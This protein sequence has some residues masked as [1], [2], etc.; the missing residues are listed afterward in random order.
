VD[1]IYEDVASPEQADI[2]LKNCRAFLKKGGYAMIAIKS[3]SID[4]TRP[5]E[6]TYAQVEGELTRELELIERINLEPFEMGH[7]FLVLR[8]RE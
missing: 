3:Q 4:V 2:L 5:P 6:E 7:L 1:I 8:K